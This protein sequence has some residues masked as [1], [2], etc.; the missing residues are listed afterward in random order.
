MIRLDRY[1][2]NRGK[3]TR[4]QLKGIIRAGRVSVNGICVKTAEYKVSEGDTVTLDGNI[5]D[6]ERY[7]YIMLN[8]PSG[9]VSASFDKKDRTVTD[10]TDKEYGNY[11]L[12]PVGRLD[13]DTTGLL[14]LT[15][16]G[17][18]AHNSLSPS[19][20][21]EKRYTAHVTGNVNED[22]V[23]KFREGIE[24]GDF[25]A[26]SSELIIKEKKDGITVT[27]VV[28]SEGK[29]HQIKRMFEAVGCMVVYLRRTAFGEIKLDEGLK[30]GEYRP[31]KD[32]EI[33]YVKA[34]SKGGNYK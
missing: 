16:D 19:G 22:T 33:E 26:R 30:E 3:G 34:I 1:L 20:H 24:L 2:A 25:T 18:F 5:V 28:I 4:S 9:V 27:E 11:K 13:K 31:L 29:F 23:K 15:N 17:A 32:S 21:V 14:I 6:N 12:F 8:K 7:V 10:I